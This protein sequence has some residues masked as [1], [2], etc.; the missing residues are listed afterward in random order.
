MQNES[1]NATDVE[2]TDE[3]TSPVEA[4]AETEPPVAEAESKPAAAEV[5]ETPTAEEPEP[6]SAEVPQQRAAEPE[7]GSGR[8]KKRKSAPKSKSVAGTKSLVVLR[9]GKVHYADEAVVVLDLDDAAHPDTDVHDVVDKLSELRE[10]AESSGRAEAVAL[11][12]ELIQ[13]KALA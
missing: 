13:A 1:A 11:V 9:E 6:P 12:A 10:A 8:G 2:M 3:P 7:A 5:P 4:Q